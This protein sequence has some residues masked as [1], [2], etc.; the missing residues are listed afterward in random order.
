MDTMNGFCKQVLDCCEDH[1]F[2]TGLVLRIVTA[3]LG[4]AASRRPPVDRHQAVLG[5]P[6]DEYCL[7]DAQENALALSGGQADTMLGH[8]AAMI[9]A[10]LNDGSVQLELSLAAVGVGHGAVQRVPRVSPQVVCLPRPHH[11]ADEQWPSAM[12]GST[13]LM[14]GDESPRNVPS[15]A[16]RGELKRAMPSRAI[17]GAPSSRSRQPG[18]LLAPVT[19][20]TLQPGR[21]QGLGRTA[22][23]VPPVAQDQGA[24]R[25]HGETAGPPGR[26]GLSKISVQLACN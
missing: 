15:S 24:G 18:L 22:S 4:I 26:D 21:L 3:G 1:A 7:L 14:R 13:G 17:S 2:A 5:V 20:A 19:S 6:V 16:T 8:A 25:N 9:L 11:G 10:D 23:A 12:H